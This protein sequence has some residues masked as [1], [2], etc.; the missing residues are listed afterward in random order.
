MNIKI[1]S[2]LGQDTWFKIIY[3]KTILQLLWPEMAHRYLLSS[4]LGQIGDTITA[5]SIRFYKI[6]N[7]NVR[8]KCSD[9]E[10]VS[11]FV[12]DQSH[13]RCQIYTMLNE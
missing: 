1:A 13:I 3:K 5:S 11:L 7:A 12:E 10:I 8:I 2:E 4:L 9:R 6:E